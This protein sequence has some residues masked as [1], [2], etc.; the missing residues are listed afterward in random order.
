MCHFRVTIIFSQK[1]MNPLCYIHVTQGSKY[2]F[3][4]VFLKKKKSPLSVNHFTGSILWFTGLF[5]SWYFFLNT[6]LVSRYHV[7]CDRV[8]R[9]CS[10]QTF[11][12]WRTPLCLHIPITLSAIITPN[13]RIVFN[14]KFHLHRH[15]DR[16]LELLA[17][18]RSS[19]ASNAHD[20]SNSRP[21][22]LGIIWFVS[23]LWKIS[24][25]TVKVESF[26]SFYSDRTMPYW[27]LYLTS[28]RIDLSIIL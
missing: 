26:Q 9:T 11:K 24:K 25:L 22:Q 12:I 7:I 21:I 28:D 14:W 6:S 5:I 13:C 20:F 17:D 16:S 23:G 8:T 15:L 27:I 4:G 18:C 10:L 1:I 19:A 2:F 3:T